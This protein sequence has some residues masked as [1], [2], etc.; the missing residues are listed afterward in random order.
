MKINQFSIT[1]TSPAQRQTEL[2]R[3]RLLRDGEGDTMDAKC[4]FETLLVRTHLSCTTPLTGKEWLHDLLATPNL[5]I[6]D[7][8]ASDQ[9]L[10]NEIFYRVALQ[11]LSFEPG[12]DFSLTAPLAAWHKLGLPLE[13]HDHWTSSDVINAYYLLLNTRGKDGQILI[14]Q[15]TANGFLTWS[16]QLPAEQKTT[17][18]QRQTLSQLRPGSLRS[19]SCLH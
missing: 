7:W 15:L 9:E 13:E 17:L 16:Y 4:L 14:D 18:L 19:R 11:L 5:A 10:T 8:L 2:A 6:D 12:V 3:I 1:P